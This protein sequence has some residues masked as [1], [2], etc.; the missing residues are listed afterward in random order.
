MNKIFSINYWFILA[1]FFVFTS[2]KATKKATVVDK[3]E[4]SE[5]ED[6]VSKLDHNSFHPEWFRAKAQMQAKMDGQGLS[7]T[8]TIISKNKELLWFNGKKFSIE[9]AR[10]LMTPDSIFIL[11]RMQRKYLSEEKDWV[12]QEYE[13]P[14]LIA[15]AIDL[16]YMQDIFIGN[17]ILDI[18][19]YTETEL[20]EE[21]VL[22]RGKKAGYTSELMIDPNT[23]HTRYF[24]LSQGENLMTVNYSDYRMIEGNQPFAFRRDIS[25]QRPGEG[26]IQVSIL[27]DNIVIN[28]EQNVKFNIPGN[29]SKM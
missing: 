23:M 3:K 8:S 26:D 6:L 15:E 10:F 19:P 28:E 14:A 1:I 25:I 2:C 16:E 9:G 18:I 5:L 24:Q 13:L 27:Y 4:N 17:P 29:Y 11:N 12:A 21:E 22:L 7:F 20:V